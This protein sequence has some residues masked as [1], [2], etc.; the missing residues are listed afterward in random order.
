[1]SDSPR[2]ARRDRREA[3]LEAATRAFARGGFAATSLDDIAAEAKITRVVIYRHFESKQELYTA[4]LDRVDERLTS[5][6]GEPD[7][8]GHHSVDGLIAAASADPDGF[9]LYY[10]YSAREPEF[11]GPADLR[12]KEMVATAEAYLREA[13]A[14]PGLRRWAATLMPSVVIE[15]IIAWLDV[16]RPNEAQAPEVIRQIVSG[17]TSAIRRS[18]TAG[19]DGPSSPSISTGTSPGGGAEREG[20]PPPASRDQTVHPLHAPGATDV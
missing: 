19:G 1:M 17:T 20:G 12:A 4:V 7:G 10:R 14:D 16:G 2:L 15:A 3:I 8:L 6:V 9:K 11:S 13:V 18:A 5:A